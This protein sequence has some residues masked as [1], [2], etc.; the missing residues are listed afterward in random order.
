M[1][2]KFILRTYIVF[3]FADIETIVFNSALYNSYN[4]KRLLIIMKYGANIILYVLIEK[5]L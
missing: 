4:I 5:L 1:S 2:Q 3:L